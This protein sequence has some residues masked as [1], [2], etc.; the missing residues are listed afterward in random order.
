MNLCSLSPSKA[1]T[2]T[3]INFNILAQKSH[4]LL[5]S[6]RNRKI[7]NQQLNSEINS[8]NDKKQNSHEIVHKQ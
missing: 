6:I 3:N 4:R 2:K 8:Q 5:D 1:Q 7:V